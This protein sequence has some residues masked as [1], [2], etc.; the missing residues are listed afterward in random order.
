MNP[1]RLMLQ[2]S[3]K[4]TPE[5]LKVFDAYF[6]PRNEAFL[7]QN[8]QGEARTRWH[9][10]RFIKNYLSCVAAVDENLGRLFEYLEQSGLADFL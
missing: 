4:H 3:S 1:F 7:R 6:R 5:Q 10:Q 8:L 9:Y 2:Y